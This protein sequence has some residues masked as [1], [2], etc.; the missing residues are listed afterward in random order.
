MDAYDVH[1]EVGS[2]AFKVRA[3]LFWTIR[4]CPAYGKMRCVGHILKMN[5]LSNLETKPIQ[6]QGGGHDDPWRSP[7]LKDHFNGR[8]EVRGKP[9]VVTACEQVQ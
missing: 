3:I 8:I 4:D 5:I 2:R 9:N 6:T 1:K 7:E